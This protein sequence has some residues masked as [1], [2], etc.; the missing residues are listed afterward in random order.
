M[1]RYAKS[2]SVPP[3]RPP[4]PVANP[5]LFQSS[6]STGNTGGQ[7]KV[8]FQDAHDDDDLYRSPS[9]RPLTTAATGATTK[10]LSPTA[11]KWQPL[12]TVEPKP[13]DGDPFSLGDSEDEKDNGLVPEPKPGASAAGDKNSAGHAK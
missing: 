9:P 2:V 6:A 3:R 12:T 13:L 1:Q 7:R 4:R 5:N 8:S 10:Q 11:S